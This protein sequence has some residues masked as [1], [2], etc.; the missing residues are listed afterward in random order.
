[1]QEIVV[2]QQLLIQMKVDIIFAHVF[3]EDVREL[4]TMCNFWSAVVDKH[5]KIYHLG[6]IVAHERI[7]EKYKLDDKTAGN[8]CRVEIK[9]FTSDFEFMPEEKWKFK[10]DENEAP[11]WWSHKHEDRCFKELNAWLEKSNFEKR[12][13]ALVHNKELEVL[14]NKTGEQIIYREKLLPAHE[15]LIVKYYLMGEKES[16]DSVWDSVWDSMRGSVWDSV[17]VSVRG[18]VRDSVWDSMRGSV[19]DSVWVSVRDSVWDSMRGSVF[20]DKR[21]PLALPKKI[22]DL[23]YIHCLITEKDN[24]RRIHVY[25]KKGMLLK[26]IDFPVKEVKPCQ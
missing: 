10:L 2:M 12:L 3:Y 25:G 9:V 17:W 6:D 8:I 5:G 15:K 22:F 26:K 19:W 14:K 13:N 21:Y 7:V 24:V 1:M 16:W 18:S 23:G 11:V 20:P 4:K